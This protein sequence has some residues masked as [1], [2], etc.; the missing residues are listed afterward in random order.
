MTRTDAET[1]VEQ[2]LI[3]MERCVEQ[4]N[5]ER[6]FFQAVKLFLYLLRYREIDQ[7]FLRYDNER[8]PQQ[9]DRTTRCLETAHSFFRS[10]RNYA[11]AQK[12]AD[13]R[14]GIE[15][16]MYFEGSPDIIEIIN[17]LAE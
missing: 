17:E 1:F 5:F 15:K 8:Y 2:A 12:I 11:R 16:Y 14:D 13:L 10:Q 4:R 6:I 9:F 7:T 3:N